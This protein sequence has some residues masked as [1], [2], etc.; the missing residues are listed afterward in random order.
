MGES[1]SALGDL[2]TPP[3]SLL[4]FLCSGGLERS[5]ASR[6]LAHSKVC[7]NGEICLSSS[8]LVYCEDTVTV[9]GQ[10]IP[11]FDSS[12]SVVIAFNKPCGL[13]IGAPRRLCTRHGSA[14]SFSALLHELARSLGVPRLFGIGRL[15]KETSGLL[16]VTNDG[17]LS[18]ACRTP[19]L[20]S[21]TYVVTSRQRRVLSEGECFDHVAQQQE[22]HAK[23]CCQRLTAAP[24][25]LNDGDVEFSEARCIGVSAR[26]QRIPRDHLSGRH[27][28]QPSSE[29]GIPSDT[30]SD[31][32]L[33]CT[34]EVQ[35]MVTLK[36]GRYRV[37]RRAVAAAGLP[38]N[39]LH[40][41]C[42]GPLVLLDPDADFQLAPAADSLQLNIPVG[43]H[44]V[45]SKDAV[46]Q[47]WALMFGERGRDCMADVRVQALRRMCDPQRSPEGDS[48][49]RAWLR[50]HEHKFIKTCTKA[51]DEG[52]CSE[53][54][55]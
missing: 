19:G 8:F 55:D 12:D 34:L 27:L 21:K 23:A 4:R 31:A 51:V 7:V 44:A 16:L 38:V 42:I 24:I 54:E 20:L 46:Q 29:T 53:D 39:E 9:D 17:T 25:V 14:S 37:V 49:L 10:N 52:E 43:Q 11:A 50:C 26:Q 48:R 3:V 18:S 45:L 6:A 15:D 40:R 13:E 22:A 30:R 28:Q 1:A 33:V 36:I 47:L 35:V 41:C 32:L 5:H 2:P